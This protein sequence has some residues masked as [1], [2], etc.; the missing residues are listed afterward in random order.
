[1][2]GGRDHELLAR[3]PEARE[4]AAGEIAAVKAPGSR[5]P[6]RAAESRGFLNALT[7]DVEDYFQ[8]SA[9][10]RAVSREDWDATPLRLEHG[11][12]QILDVAD[13]AG[14]RA[15]FFFLGW[16][17]ERRPDL[18]RTV[19]GAGHELACHS[20]EHR[21]VYSMTPAEFRSDLRRA[22]DAIEQAGGERCTLY[23]A[24]SY[25]VTQDSLWALEVL[26]EEG[27]RTDSSVYPVVHDRYGIPDAPRGPFRPLPGT[28]EFV[29][30]P[31]SA[32]RL[33]GVNVPCGGGG[34]LRLFPF[35]L[36]RAFLRRINR[37]EGRPAMVY[38]HPWE[39]DPEQPRIEAGSVR[40][41]RHRVNL[42]RT[43][44]RLERLLGEFRFGP[45]SRVI[46]EL[47]GAEGFPEVPLRS[48]G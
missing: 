9:F 46:E 16:L 45:L 20:Y 11:L 2:N 7:V 31:A 10:E 14:A 26:A 19:A 28:P 13:A 32:V 44:S 34:Y 47:G 18:V 27:I 38:V 1:M 40:V 30:F 37:R 4:E 15:T 3:T 21:L 41:L 12:R 33:A 42:R 29:E 48:P 39:F 17:A 43:R 24:P 8:V 35:W 25:S 6:S 36:T 22:I 23:R 5:P